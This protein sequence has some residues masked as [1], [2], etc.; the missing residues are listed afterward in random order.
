M[1]IGTGC[2]ASRGFAALWL[3]LLLLAASPL[4]ARAIT[5]TGETDALALGAALAGPGS[6]LVLTGAAL[7][8]PQDGAALS[9]GVF[10]NASG[11][12]GI[13]AGIVLSSGD[14]GAYAD[15]PNLEPDTTTNY[16]S[17]GSAEQDLLADL[18][19]GDAFRTHDVTQLDLSFDLL[20]GRQSL[21]LDL[22]LGS[23][24]VPEWQSTNF[25]DGFGVF[26]NGTNIAELWGLPMTV[27][28]PAMAPLAGTELDA[29]LAPGGDPLIR[30]TASL[31]GGVLRSQGNV[32]TLIV[33]DSSDAL[34]DTTAFVS[35][36][37]AETAVATPEPH[38]ALLLALGMAGLAG[39]GRRDPALSRRAR[40]RARRRTR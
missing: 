9:S 1:R 16:G 25:R 26:L 17:R 28:H 38:S 39:W 20:P 12:Y 18:V 7:H 21:S 13:G 24:E 5:V 14:V 6:G 22:L 29:V 15:G 2:E 19:T 36:L 23:E 4:P 30:L 11:T 37:R 31:A 27:D 8:G 33:F 10:D 3:G 40:D 35:N 34:L 32:L